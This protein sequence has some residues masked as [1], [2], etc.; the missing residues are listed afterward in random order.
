MPSEMN[1]DMYESTNDAHASDNA[2]NKYDALE[3]EIEWRERKRTKVRVKKMRPHK[4][5]I[6]SLNEQAN[7]SPHGWS[8]IT[9]PTRAIPAGLE[10]AADTR[11]A[12][13]PTFHASRHEREW[14]INYLG[15][16]YTDSLIT[17]VLHQVKGGKE[18]T[19]YC[20]RAH[21]ATGVE[22]IAA[23]VYRPRMFRSLRNDSLYRQ[24]RTTL[25][26]EGKSAQRNRR[27]RLAVEKRTKFGQAVLHSNW[28]ANE[29][30][31]LRVLY[32]AGAD[33][34]KP[35]ASGENAMLMS[36][37]G[38]EGNPAPTLNH[39]H[40]ARGEAQTVFERLMHNVELM[41]AHQRIHADLSAFN[42]LYWRGAIM[43]I[44]FPQAIDPFVNPHAFELLRRDI[45]R[46]CDY[47]ARYE[48]KANAFDLATALW[49][50]YMV[51][52]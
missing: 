24:G 28:L 8:G 6:E 15:P 45:Q 47:F 35:F 3:N 51:V 5:I 46:L 19:V 37:V 41:L 13:N 7:N 23:K 21:P 1:H 18:A 52:E 14:I 50:K 39:I 48:V 34:P 11:A 42:V 4:Q 27:V 36:Y 43:I 31:T 29:F 30:S 38:A 2:A 40:L 16:F 12:F 49:K 9:Y 22:L 20:C 17:D 33:I 44:D 10:P 26:E 25:D 32:D